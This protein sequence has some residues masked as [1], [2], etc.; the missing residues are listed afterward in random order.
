MTDPS[1]VAHSIRSADGLRLRILQWP[2]P[3]ADADPVLLVHGLAE[4]G[5]RYDHVAAALT[6]AGYRV[7]L[8]E[9]RGHGLSEG[10]RGHVSRWQDYVDDLAAALALLRDPVH[11][12]AH[13]MGGLVALD[14]LRGPVADRVRSVALSNPLMGV[15]FDPPKLK[16]AAAGLLS[17][18]LP[19]LPLSNELD[20][21]AISRDPAV[22][23]AYQA[24]ALVYATI[25]P[26][27]YRQ[28]LA[29]RAR[30]FEHASRY[31]T[32]MLAMLGT[33][34]AICDHRATVRLAQ[35]WGGAGGQVRL[36]DGLYHEL[37]NEPE[38]DRVL[39]DLVDW[40]DARE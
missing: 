34:D 2:A 33:A 17:R 26:R 11:L 32:P 18:V 29:A 7:S 39:A 15:A 9:L 8:V 35:A 12:V 27:W 16:D 21:A 3:A 31:K 28:M 20:V 38:R 40:L 19:T 10:R 30:V 5:G 22:V 23:A 24:D 13:S 25:T 4:H 1:P 36:Y 14:A 6:A 37:F